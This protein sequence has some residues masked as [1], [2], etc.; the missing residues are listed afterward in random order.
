MNRRGTGRQSGGVWDFDDA[1]QKE[2]KRVV[3]SVFG[4]QLLV[5][6]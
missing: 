1:E 5:L 4:G 3:G 6:Q 2:R